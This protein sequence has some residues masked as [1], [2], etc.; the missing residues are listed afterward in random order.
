MRREVGDE[1]T[2]VVE[3][4]NETE[5]TQEGGGEQVRVGA[6]HYDLLF[7]DNG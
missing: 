6:D 5:E 2:L 7:Q 1:E 4:F 3:G